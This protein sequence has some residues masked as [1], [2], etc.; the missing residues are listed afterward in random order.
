MKDKDLRHVLINSGI[1]NVRK[2][3]DFGDVLEYNLSP[4][5]I[6]TLNNRINAICDY[7]GIKTIVPEAQAPIVAKKK[8]ELTKSSS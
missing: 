1:I 7:L 8:E 6:K 4:E 3:A 5:D 2:R